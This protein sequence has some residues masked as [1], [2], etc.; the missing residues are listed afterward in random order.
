MVH[1]FTQS[2]IHVILLQPAVCMLAFTDS[3]PGVIVAVK[4]AIGS[5]QAPDN[6]SHPNII[7]PRAPQSRGTLGAADVAIL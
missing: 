5:A 1:P 2:D 7:N 3:Q 4:S 6:V